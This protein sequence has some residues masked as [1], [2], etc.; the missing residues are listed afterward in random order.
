MDKACLT[1]LELFGNPFDQIEEEDRK[2]RQ[3]LG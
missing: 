1:L 2:Q 3:M